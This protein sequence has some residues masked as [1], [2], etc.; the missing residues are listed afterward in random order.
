MFAK[1]TLSSVSPPHCRQLEWLNTRKKF[2][3]KKMS[4]TSIIII[5]TIGI[6]AKQ[7]IAS[8]FVITESILRSSGTTG[9]MVKYQEGV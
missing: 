7:L 2:N 9:S 4:K 5:V 8:D 3:I 6:S 1:T